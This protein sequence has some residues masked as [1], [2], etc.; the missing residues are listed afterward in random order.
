MG[1]RRF[2]RFVVAAALAV[3]GSS[4][5]AQS[6][7]SLGSATFTVVGGGFVNTPTSIMIQKGFL[8]KYGVTGKLLTLPTGPVIVAS[9]VGG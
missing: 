8:A 4:S 5:G 2:V 7:P 9:L 1:M 6:A 3:I